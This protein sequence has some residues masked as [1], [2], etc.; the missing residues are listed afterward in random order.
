MT[1]PQLLEEVSFY[2]RKIAVLEDW[3][4]FLY[5]RECIKKDHPLKDQLWVIRPDYIP[6]ITQMHR[7]TPIQLLEQANPLSLYAGRLN[8]IRWELFNNNIPSD[9]W[10]RFWI[11]IY[12]SDLERG[13][14]PHWVRQ[15]SRNDLPSFRL[16]PLA[17][18][19]K[20]D[21][22]NIDTVG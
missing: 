7:M 18:K 8:D 1:R 16:F 6:T 5:I 9:K 13:Y 4:R 14:Y 11:L 3:F 19:Y 20:T 15:F 10:L 17:K 12:M 22:A 2:I 21:G